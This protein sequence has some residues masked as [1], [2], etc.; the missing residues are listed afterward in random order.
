MRKYWTIQAR[1]QDSA[2]ILIYE[3]I[4][5]GFF[6]EGI[7]AKRFA[8]DLKALG[9][10]DRLVVRINSPG[11]SVF[12]GLAIYNQLK[13]HR[14]EK[15]VHIDGIAASIASVIAMSGDR[16]IMPS[17]ALMMV[18]DPSGLAMGTAEDMRK[19][20]EALD[21][22]KTGIIT[23]YQSKTGLD[24]KDIADLMS[25]ETWMTAEDAL[26]YGFV[27]NVEE[28]VKMA[29]SFDLD[30]FN[31]KKI[32]KGITNMLPLKPHQTDA[33]LERERVTDLLA[34]GR[35]FNCAALAEQY[36]VDGGS[37]DGLREEILQQI[38]A[39]GRP[40]PGPL[41]VS[42]SPANEGQPFRNLGEQL[43]AVA[44]STRQ[45]VV[46]PRLMQITNA[47]TGANEGF[48]SE[49]GFL[50]QQDFSSEL[51][52]R[53][54]ETGLL[55]SRCRRIPVSGNGLN[56]NTVEESSRATGSRWGG[57]QCY[58]TEEAGTGTPKKP[59]F[60]RMELKLRKLMGIAYATD[61]LLED[62]TALDAVFS[63]AFQEEIGFMLD[64][65]IV[66]GTGVGH[67]LGILNSD[68]LITVSKETGQLAK[69]VVTENILNMWARLWARS[70]QSAVWF[71][72]RD[73]LPQLYGMQVTLGTGGAPLFMP[74][75]GLSGS[76]YST[77][78]GRPIISIEQ[79]ETLGTVGDIVLADL[80]QYLLIDKGGISTAVSI[81]VAFLTDE[82]AF[83]FT[84]RVDGQPTWKEPLTPY[85]GTNTQ[86]PF[87]VLE[88]R[89]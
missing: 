65:A 6:E 85:K 41:M 60:G 8:E 23:A 86:S 21:K 40:S 52:K 87:I 14:A 71:I 26:A 79:C 16:V 74:P 82:Q 5:E 57:V 89:D 49:G 56:I 68:A 55:A 30:K 73:V 38:K 36:V 33:A 67:P 81:H 39:K 62:T 66:R 13:G 4:G 42:A 51:L 76:P 83:R 48:P 80:S 54:Y 25:E 32:P 34:V 64:D 20:A 45:S 50:V 12:E 27:D 70:E 63:Q 44:K 7:G 17:N 24:K 72:N 3:Q 88:T 58:W 69:T 37:V 19:M 78:L 11:G 2:E 15:E 18:H 46:D 1:D 10:V 75:G 29:A 28:A 84:L 53:A 43:A 31:F 59:K 9:D 47:A 35:E 61:E 22:I 77:L